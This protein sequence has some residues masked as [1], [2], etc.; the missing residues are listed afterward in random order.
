MKD[1]LFDELCESVKEGGALMNKSKVLRVPDELEALL[2]DAFDAG[3]TIGP[4]LDGFPPQNED[5]QEM[6][7]RVLDNNPVPALLAALLEQAG[8]IQV[9]IV[10][11]TPCDTKIDFEPSDIWYNDPRL[12]PCETGERRSY[13]L[14]SIREEGRG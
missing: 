10:R 13:W 1:E 3:C 12:P 14:L 8:A 2:I 11:T 5:C 9:D 7:V 4:Q 6:L